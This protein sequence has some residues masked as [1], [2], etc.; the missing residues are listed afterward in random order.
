MRYDIT[1][2]SEGSFRLNVLV[3]RCFWLELDISK[4][5]APSGKECKTMGFS[6]ED[7]LSRLS[8]DHEKVQSCKFLPLK[9]SKNNLIIFQQNNA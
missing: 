6:P 2:R 4:N 8:Q 7:V 5:N 1:A 3:P 9:T